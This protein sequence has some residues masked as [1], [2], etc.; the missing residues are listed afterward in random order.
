M[1]QALRARGARALRTAGL[2][3]GRATAGARMLPSV[4]IVGAQRCGT[5]SMVKALGQHHDVLTLWHKGVHY[6]DVNYDRGPVWYRAH[7]PLHRPGRTAEASR[8]VTLE[9]SPYYMFHP[10]APGRIAQDL[11]G[12]RVLVLVRDP[13][14]RA[15]SAHAH[16]TARGFESLPFSE[17]LAAEP[18]RLRGEVERMLE[19][20]SYQ[21]RDLQHHAYL[22]RGRYAEQLERLARHLGREHI[23]AVDSHDFFSRP[24]EVFAGVTDFLGLPR[25]DDIA[26]DRHNAARRP[27][28]LPDSLRDE[29][30]TYFR[31]H[32]ER[33]AGWLG[34]TPSWRR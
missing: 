34:T 33:L 21:S 14:E 20:P 24:A 8:A 4:L 28:P 3:V 13:V 12:V 9:S 15:F 10:L 22:A 1:Q 27:S 5:T 32:D 23:H 16:E 25:Q 30:D 2:A 31:P 7:F 6:F 19:D 26:F 29:L 11:P 18:D 17:A